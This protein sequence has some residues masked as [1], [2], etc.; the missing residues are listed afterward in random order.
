MFNATPKRWKT[1]RWIVCVKLLV[2][3][4]AGWLADSRSTAMKYVQNINFISWMYWFTRLEFTHL[5]WWVPSHWFLSWLG[6]SLWSY[7]WT[8][9]LNVNAKLRDSSE[10]KRR[11][12][13][14]YCKISIFSTKL[15]DPKFS[16]FYLFY[17]II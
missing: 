15:L 5:L 9:V 1:R 8:G 3:W 7:V 4:K 10:N 11:S 17:L 6:P 16:S 14:N 12:P 13:L 2:P